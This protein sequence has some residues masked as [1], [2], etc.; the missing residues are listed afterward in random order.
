MSMSSVYSTDSYVSHSSYTPQNRSRK[1]SMGE[2]ASDGGG[3]AVA[4]LTV[5][6]MESEEE[7]V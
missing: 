7:K 6:Q 2:R 5:E 4:V 3:S 1:T